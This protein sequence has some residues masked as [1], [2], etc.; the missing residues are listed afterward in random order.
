MKHTKKLKR[1]QP[2]LHFFIALYAIVCLLPMLF[3]LVVSFSSEE[4][5]LEKGFS[6]FPNGF[7]LKAYEYVFSFGSQLAQS[8]LVT[9]FV[10]VAGTIWS[11]AVMTPFAYS[12]SRSKFVLRSP[13]SIMLLITMLFSG[14]E[15]ANYL[16]NTTMYNLRDSIAILILPGYSVMYVIVLRTYIQS[17]IPESVFESAKIDGAGEWRTFMQIC[18]PMMIPALASVGFLLAV[19]YWTDWYRSYMYITSPSKTTLQLLMV[20]IEKNI[21][22]LTNNSNI[23]PEEYMRLKNEIPSATGQMAVLIFVSGPILVAYP[24]FQKYFVKGI[25]MGAVKG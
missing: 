13:L 23:P 9:I 11:L 3:V 15:L 8:Y 2:V 21:D 24:F 22:F 5:I 18:L 7:S 17:N 1:S 16:V 12:L 14:G 20:R 19:G 6:F 25:T 4:S 10:T